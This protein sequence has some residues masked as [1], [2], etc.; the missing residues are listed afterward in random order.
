MNAT[1]SI[2]LILL[3]GHEGAGACPNMHWVRGRIHLEQ[4]GNLIERLKTSS[5]CFFS[6]PYTSLG[7]NRT[8]E[9][10]P[11]IQKLCLFFL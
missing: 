5:L 9:K 1:F 6:Y 8:A 7:R 4:V 2:Q 10:T 3:L 11:N